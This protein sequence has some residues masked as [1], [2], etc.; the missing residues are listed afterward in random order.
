MSFLWWKVI[1]QV[2][3]KRTS[4]Y[5]SGVFF[6]FLACDVCMGNEM[7]KLQGHHNI[8]VVLKFNFC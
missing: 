4:Y 6:F 2:K 8:V 1:T 3:T 5:S 7:T